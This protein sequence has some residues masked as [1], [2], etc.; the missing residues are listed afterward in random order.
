[1]KTHQ[2]IDERSLAL[3]RAVVAKIDADPERSGLAKAREVCRRW[4]ERN[5]LPVCRE[6]MRILERPWS[7]IRQVLCDES[8]LGRR[9]RQSD[10]FCGILAPRE[11]WAIYRKFREHETRR[12]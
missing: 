1:M 12:S 8:E 7:Q 11:R 3:A 4:C 5:P 6:W 10:P 9:L 2:Q